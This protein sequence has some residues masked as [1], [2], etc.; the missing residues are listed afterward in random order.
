MEQ[1]HPQGGQT[2]D[3]SQAVHFPRRHPPV[4]TL[5]GRVRYSRSHF[6]SSSSARCLDLRRRRTDCR[7]HARPNSREYCSRIAWNRSSMHFVHPV[8]SLRLLNTGHGNAR[9][10]SR[11]YRKNSA[12]GGLPSTHGPEQSQCS[13]SNILSSARNASSTAC[14]AASSLRGQR[15]SSRGE[16]IGI[17]NQYQMFASQDF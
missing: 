6:C 14:A 3:P 17:S 9:Q 5:P 10:S 15:P 13:A 4:E 16:L 11:G 7:G 12:A 1:R 8:G 2:T